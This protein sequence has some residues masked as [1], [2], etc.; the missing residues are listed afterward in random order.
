MSLLPEGERQS[1]LTGGE[2]LPAHDYRDGGNTLAWITHGFSS[3]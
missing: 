1:G 2:I 3:F